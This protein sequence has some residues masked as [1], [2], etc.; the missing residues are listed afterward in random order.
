MADSAPLPAVS[1]DVD[2]AVIERR[3]LVRYELVVARAINSHEFAHLGVGL[4]LVVA[5]DVVGGLSVEIDRGAGGIACNAGIGEGKMRGAG[6]NI[7]RD[8]ACAKY[9]HLV[10]PDVTRCSASCPCG[11]AFLTG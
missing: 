5:E 9:G 2:T 4:D 10:K 8:P 1:I 11:V 3:K 7:E 6:G